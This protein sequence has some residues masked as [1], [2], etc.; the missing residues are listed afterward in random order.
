M[1]GVQRSLGVLLVAIAAVLA[2]ASCGSDS[3]GELDPKPSASKDAD[4]FTAEQ[5]EV[6]DAVDQYAE[7]VQ[8]YK[9]GDSAD[10]AKVATPQVISL[11]STIAKPDKTKDEIGDYEMKPATVTV[12]GDT[13]SY[14][15]CSDF[16][17]MFTVDAGETAPGAGAKVGSAL[18][19][20][21]TLVKDGDAWLVSDPKSTGEPC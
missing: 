5:R 13:A 18:K 2:L 9:A 10:L 21:F 11:L 17:K 12:K 6:I 19:I 14:E 1:V 16:S 4:G 15:G 3:S 7:T 20:D 8:T